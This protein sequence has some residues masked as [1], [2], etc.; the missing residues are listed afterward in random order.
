MEVSDCYMPGTSGKTSESE[1]QK[2]KCPS[3]DPVEVK[4]KLGPNSKLNLTALMS[5][6]ES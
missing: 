4:V 1:Q 2:A 3:Q 6:K 5:N